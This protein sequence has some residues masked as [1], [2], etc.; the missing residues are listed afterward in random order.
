MGRRRSNGEDAV[1]CARDGRASL[2]Q[3]EPIVAVVPG[4]PRP[5]ARFVT[6]SGGVRVSRPPSAA[7]ARRTSWSADD[8]GNSPIVGATGRR[9]SDGEDAVGCARDGRAPILQLAS[10]VAVIPDGPRPTARFVTG[11][12]GARVSRPPFAASAR[13][14]SWSADDHGNSPIVGTT[15]RRASDGEDAVGCA[16][17]GR[18]PLLQLESIVAVVPGVP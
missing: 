9:G 2:L 15:G 8:H 12:G 6:G 1:G 16:R 17:D 3:L 13:R 18:A 7:S 11:S 5:T 4:G 14:T 10:V